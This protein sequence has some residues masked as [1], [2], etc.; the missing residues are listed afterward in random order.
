MKQ[1]ISLKPFHTFGTSVKAAKYTE[2]KSKYDLQ[3]LIPVQE[4][5]LV[6]GGGSNI[7]FT[8]DFE[9]LVIHNKIKGV[10]IISENDDEV[11]LQVGSGENWHALVLWCIEN[12]YAGIEN[13]SL[14]PGC[15]GAAPIQNIGAYGVEFK[16]VFHSLEAIDL[17]T[18]STKI[19]NYKDCKFDYRDSI[20][21]NELK[22]KFCITS[23]S[24]CLSKK[25]QFNTSYGV[26]KDVLDSSGE[27]LSLK[28]IS[29]AIIK[30]RS[31]KLPDPKKIGNSGSFF[32]NPII[33][34]TQFS[35]LKSKFPNIPIYPVGDKEVKIAAGWLIDN[36]GWKGYRNG[37]AGV[38]K[39]QAL[40]LV[41]YGDAKGLEIWNLAKSIQ[42]S[43]FEE[44]GILLETEVNIL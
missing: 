24:I 12:G 21:K 18:G 22:G 28:S 8:K 41:N 15:V 35:L 11:I 3:D 26:I 6:L 7:L 42:I 33:S 31:E 19:F 38:H 34:L 25:P 23:V 13:L 36:L 20:F 17:Q 4:P 44:Y 32:M 29:N 37:D 39:N 40:V 43:V 1:N 16:D 5:F 9:G 27:E 30:I 10:G 14:I 2:I